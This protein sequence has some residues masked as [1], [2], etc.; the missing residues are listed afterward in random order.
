M[1]TMIEGFLSKS[2]L[3]NFNSFYREYN[4]IYNKN[5]ITIISKSFKPNY[6]YQT[7]R[8]KILPLTIESLK[9]K[10]IKLKNTSAFTEKKNNNNNK[11]KD[12]EFKNSLKQKLKTIFETPR[13]IHRNRNFNCTSFFNTTFK[14]ST[15][16]ETLNNNNNLMNFVNDYE[17][18][19]FKDIKYLN[20]EYNENEIYNDEKFYEDIIEEKIKYLK[21]NSNFDKTKKFEKNFYY[22]KYRKEINLT[23]HSMQITFQKMNSENDIPNPKD[24]QTFNIEFP[25]ELLPI[26]YYKG[27][28]TFIKFLSRVIRIENNFEKIYF[29]EDKICEQLNKIKEFQINDDELNDLND[30][31]ILDFIQSR[32]AKN[33]QKK[34][35]TTHLKPQILNKNSNILKFNNFIFF[36]ITNT[37]TYIVTIT[38]P[39]IQLNILDNKIVINNYIDYELLFY[40]YKRK[41]VNW[42]YYIIKNLSSYSKFRTI[43]QQISRNSKIYEQN[44]YLKEQKQKINTFSEETL[45][46]IYTDQ[47]NKNVI[48][49]FKSFYIIAN[50]IDLDY[51]LEKRYHIHFNFLQFIKLYEIA[52]YSNRILFLI[53]FM[54]AN[55]EFNTLYFNFEEFD[56]F[57]INIWISNINQF[58]KKTIYQK[59]IIDESS[60]EF[61]LFPKKIKVEYKKPKYS[62]MKLEDDKDIIK[63][64]D[65]ENELEK[66]LVDTIGGTDNWTKFLNSC[67]QKLDEPIPVL[68]TI[69]KKGMRKKES[70]KFR[71]YSHDSNRDSRKKLLSKI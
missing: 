45:I 21:N 15:D 43:F 63:S 60:H 35:R 71:Y 30:S 1:K 65:I 24:I 58:S 26:F 14:L 22:G 8:K 29:E 42:E 9:T 41:F 47:F 17:K 69:H 61:D 36:W 70:K 66:L 4:N 12:F 20:L 19:F 64:L 33:N 59:E 46:N 50:I 49:I 53:K 13:I 2:N 25:F 5:K 40:I 31:Y 51:N 7:K 56:K 38:V 11:K 6:F 27:L 34:E 54:T 10:K 55:K 28:H 57:D 3:K 32:N 67:L 39:S 16:K 62:I 18:D 52:K 68:P 37:K 23:F 44:V 48:I